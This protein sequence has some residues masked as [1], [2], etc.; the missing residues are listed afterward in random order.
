MTSG[1]GAAAAVAPAVPAA[2]SILAI[3]LRATS[4][5]TTPGTSTSARRAISTPVASGEVSRSARSMPAEK[6]TSMVS[7]SKSRSISS[8][9]PPPGSPQTKSC[10]RSA[11]NCFRVTPRSAAALVWLTRG[12]AWKYGT[13]FNSR[14]RRV[15]TLLMRDPPAPLA[16][17]SRLDTLPR[18]RTQPSDHVVPQ[19]FRLQS[20]GVGAVAGDLPGQP[21]DHADVDDDLVAVASPA[22]T[23]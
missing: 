23:G 18:L 7:P 8:P 19:R 6:I 5:S 1:A 14:T 2:A 20:H 16:G 10:Q 15:D 9:G 11:S 3:T 17:Y 4:G 21:V 12:L 22:R 13:M